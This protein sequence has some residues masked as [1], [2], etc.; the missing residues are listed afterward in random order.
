MKNEQTKSKLN[1]EP[2]FYDVTDEL[3]NITKTDSMEEHIC[4]VCL[5]KFDGEYWKRLCIGCY[6]KHGRYAKR[7]GELFYRIHNN[8]YLGSTKITKEDVDKFIR[9]NKYFCP[10]GIGEYCRQREDF[11]IWIAYEKCLPSGNISFSEKDNFYLFRAYK[12]VNK[13]ELLSW[14]KKL[15]YEYNDCMLLD[16]NVYKIFDVYTYCD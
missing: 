14:L 3:S 9:D 1:K 7:I 5:N 10:F 13:D 15:K 11:N 8:I 16:L 12:T 4:K 6:R 2:I